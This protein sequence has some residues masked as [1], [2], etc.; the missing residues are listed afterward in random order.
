MQ[1]GDSGG[2]RGWQVREEEAEVEEVPREDLA[3]NVMRGYWQLDPRQRGLW[4]RLRC[5][6][7]A[8]PRPLCMAGALRPSLVPPCNG[9]RIARAGWGMAFRVLRQMVQEGG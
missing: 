8:P 6:S 3:P 9:R 2:V 4:G 5:A 1:E 7:P